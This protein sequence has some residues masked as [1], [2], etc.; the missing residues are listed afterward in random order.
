MKKTFTYGSIIIALVFLG[1]TVLYW[2]TPAGSLP[3]YLPGFEAGST[4]V[5]FKHG[6]GSLILSVVLFAYAWF[7]TG[8]STPV[9]K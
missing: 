1:L 3:H 5:H 4:K 8:P 6:L 9:Q 7:A 2:M